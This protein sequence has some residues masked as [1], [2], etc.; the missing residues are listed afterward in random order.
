MHICDG[1]ERH[2]YLIMTHDCL[3]ELK[4]LIQALDW[5]ENDIFCH[6]GVKAPFGEDAILGMVKH[7]TLQCISSESVSWGGSSQV[8]CG[9]RLLE[10][11]VH[12]GHHMYYHMLSGVD[13]PV[14]SHNE[15]VD[16]FDVNTGKN[17]IQ[18]RVRIPQKKINLRMC[19]YHF[20][21]DRFVGKKRNIWKYIDFAMCYVQRAMGVNRFRG[22]PISYSSA[23]W[24]ITEELAK[25]YVD[26]MSEILKNIAIHIVRMKWSI[27][28]S[29]ITHHSILR[30]RI[31]D[32]WSTFGSITMM[33]RP[34]TLRWMMP[35]NFLMENFCSPVSS[36]CLNR[37]T[38]T[39]SSV[40][41]MRRLMVFDMLADCNM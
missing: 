27:L 5:P 37:R 29:C 8:R 9:L 25:F 3:D 31:C 23:L 12:S 40:S 22:I 14:K 18:K 24:S 30:I 4:I 16:F 13:F 32:L 35:R 2:A 34:R 20:L 39:I 10:T 15:I 41:D 17:Y 33:S 11:A 28:Q 19:Q 21:Q 26:R 36:I 6:I 1:H 7:A 38:Y